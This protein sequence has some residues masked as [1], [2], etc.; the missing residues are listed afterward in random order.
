MKTWLRWDQ[1]IPHWLRCLWWSCCGAGLGMFG[2]MVWAI[3]AARMD[4]TPEWE[5][6]SII[7]SIVYACVGA[8]VGIAG[9]L[10]VAGL[11]G[12]RRKGR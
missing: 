7:N 12:P 4:R 1:E 6:H 3:V 11:R 10:L 8:L 2:G 9:G 5:V